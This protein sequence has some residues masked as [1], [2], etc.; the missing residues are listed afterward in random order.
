MNVQTCTRWVGRSAR[1][2]IMSRRSAITGLCAVVLLVRPVL[3]LRP[4]SPVE[5]VIAEPPVSPSLPGPPSSVSS[6]APEVSRSS[7]SPPSSTSFPRRCRGRPCRRDPEPVVPATPARRS[8]PHR[9]RGRRC[10][11][12]RQPIVAAP[13]PSQSSSS[14]PLRKLMPRRRRRDRRPRPRRGRRRPRRPRARRRR[15]RRALV[16]AGP[17][18]QRVGAARAVERVVVGRRVGAC[19]CRP[20]RAAMSLPSSP[21]TSS[22]PRSQLFVRLVP[23]EHVDAV[24]LRRVSLPP[25][26]ASGCRALR[27]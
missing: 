6:P 11:S 24:V 20:R 14:P 8:S 25:S 16:L 27:R 1:S 12:R 18:A 4:R 5:A 2:R 21:E 26:P 7:A 23:L 15:R 22:R 13:P 10:R 3:L 9:R 19:R 17:R